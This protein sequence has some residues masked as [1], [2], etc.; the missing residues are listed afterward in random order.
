M[1]KQTI[2]II[3]LGYV[4]LCTAVGFASKGY[5]LI[6][7]D[8]DPKK[9]ELVNQ[10]VPPFYEVN[11]EKLIRKILRKGC[12]KCTTDYKEAILESDITFITVGTPSKPDGSINLRYVEDS[13]KEIGKAL[14]EKDG[15][16][17][18]AVKST[19]IPGT[20]EKLVKPTIERFS[21]KQ[22][23]K[24]FGLCVN[25]EFLREGSAIHDVL[26]PDRIIIGE[27]DK[28]SGNTIETLFRNF[29]ENEIPPI[30]RTNLPTAELIKYA[31]NAFLAMKISFINEIANICEK[32][33]GVDVT[34]VAKGI[35]LDKRIGP[36]F[37][38]AGL[39]YGGSC[40]PKDV[41]ALV[42]FSKSLGYKPK[43]L[44]EA[45]KINQNQPYKAIELCKKA[46]GELK[47]KRIAILGLAFKPNTDDVREATSIKIIKA[48]LKEEAKII[49]YDPAAMSNAK[50]KLG[51]KI[52]YATSAI[53]CIK[54]A[55]CCV[56]ITEWNEF[57]KLQPQ[58]FIRNMKQPVIIDGRRIY[59]PKKF[60][61]KLRFMAVGLGD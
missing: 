22:C 32:I 21:R 16:H 20:T 6:T 30:I 25:P 24:D 55:D 15:Y 43:L 3:G 59:D 53:N 42:A 35:G 5:N 9:V 28:K 48:L 39:G 52:Q 26:H 11:L 23:G 18:I 40:L 14:N 54:G 1:A 58:D 10:G 33:P 19:V 29:Y 36:L 57:T 60:S 27:Y 45:N 47:A 17:L 41:K 51:D 46:I 13:A 61:H 8:N 44:I 4:G 2:S 38:N 34:V 50:Q 56:I 12:L 31:N 37:L 49:A 7:V